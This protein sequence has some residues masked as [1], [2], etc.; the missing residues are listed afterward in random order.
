M[1]RADECGLGVG[2][3]KGVMIDHTGPLNTC[4]DCNR[5]FELCDRSV[6]L[7]ISE[8]TFDLSVWDVFG[9]LAVGAMLVLPQQG[10]SRDP[11]IMSRLVHSYAVTH[12]NSV[13][14]FVV[15][16]TDYLGASSY[17]LT[18]SLEVV[19]MSGDYIPTGLP[20]ELHQLLPEVRM[21][22]MGGATEGSIWSIVYE[23][24]NPAL[25]PPWPTIP[26]GHEMENQR[27]YVLGGTA[28]HRPLCV[29]GEIAIGGVGVAQGYW[30][31]AAKSASQFKVI[32]GEWVY[33]TGDIGRWRS[34]GEMEFL[35][36][37]DSQ[38]K[39]HGFRVELGEVEHAS[40]RSPCV[41]KAVASVVDGRLICYCVCNADVNPD[42]VYDSVQAVCSEAL[43]AYMVPSTVMVIE[44]VPIS[45]NGKLDRS[46]LPLPESAALA[47]TEDLHV[48]TEVEAQVLTAFTEF[49]PRSVGI[50][51]DFFVH[52]G[53]SIIAVRLINRVNQLFECQL[54]VS[55]L[56][57]HRTVSTIATQIQQ[58]VSRSITE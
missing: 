14:Q 4:L 16:L 58:H 23:I 53:N 32:Q 47:V 20:H 18:E 8:L 12:W 30:K 45:A 24:G 31:S 21:V 42:D 55:V 2:E 37:K 43:P 3:P 54:S 6:V 49:L 51:D 46:Q 39:L 7:G 27:M 40:L 41:S 13:P 57:A 44:S 28:E 5:R 29:A 50:H 10:T 17:Q 33:M 34:N 52:G 19:M 48:L 9:T 11:A 25:L 22:S 35:G 15:M 38:V 56:L 26:Y 1:W 36:R